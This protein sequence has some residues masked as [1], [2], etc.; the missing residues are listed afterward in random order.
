MEKTFIEFCERGDLIQAQ[1]YLRL[2]PTINVSIGNEYAF[3]YACIYGYLNVAQWLASIKPYLYV[4]Q[5]NKI[6]FKYLRK[7]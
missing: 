3:R 4:I 5:Y 7:P 6:D 1:E 2:N